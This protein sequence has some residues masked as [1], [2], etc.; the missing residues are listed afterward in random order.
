MGI[1]WACI[2]ELDIGVHLD[3]KLGILG[4]KGSLGCKGLGY[5]IDI[6]LASV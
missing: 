4:Y 5:Q 1:E 3:V 6:S 2:L